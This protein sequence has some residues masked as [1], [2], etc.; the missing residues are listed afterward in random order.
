MRRRLASA[1]SHADVCL[2]RR[3]CA[4][5][6]KTGWAAEARNETKEED[7]PRP[8]V[9]EQLRA[10]YKMV[11]PDLFHRDPVA[12]AANESSFQLL[13]EYLN[14]SS[15]DET[16]PKS[17][18]FTFSFYTR[19]EGGNGTKKVDICLPP[20]SR[21]GSTKKEDER[22]FSLGTLK[23]LARLFEQ[24]GLDGNLQELQRGRMDEWDSMR[25]AEFLP[26]AVESLRQQENNSRTALFRETTVRT[27]LFVGRGVRVS[28]AQNMMDR[29][30]EDRLKVLEKLAHALDCLPGVNLQDLTIKLGN[31][32]G[33]D[34]NGML[35]LKSGGRAIDFINSISDANIQL[36]HRHRAIWKDRVTLE[37]Q[38]A[39]NLGIASI[40]TE[41][42]IASQP[43][44]LAFLERLAFYSVQEGR[45]TQ[46]DLSYVTLRV[47]KG[48][49]RRQKE[50]IGSLDEGT[51]HI[52]V[53]L[54]E[55]PELVYACVLQHG[56][57]AQEIS[58]AY[59]ARQEHLTRLKKLVRLRLGLRHIH[60]D[61]CVTVDQFCSCCS[62]LLRVSGAL[63][64][65]LE[66]SSLKI[67]DRNKV[68]SDGQCIFL[69]WDFRA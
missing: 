9:K 3:W 63:R 45:I 12:K 44:Y 22:S 41:P 54:D 30:A 37:K 11:H 27:A 28:Y 51:G 65:V 53:Q 42:S 16:Q 6:T 58:E 69:K 39:E 19:V 64:P 46:E 61:N 8:T 15:D 2:S 20:P 43:S 4:G 33:I 66:G 10:L 13:Q 25:L 29:A 36:A 35:W 5:R 34:R 59:V 1:V 50:H 18:L 68:C 47:C 38:I 17:S 31:R 14:F 55:H 24:C 32:S 21:H 57:R 56:R 52:L 48:W 49:Q 7:R 26:P 60:H 23:A 67:S 40:S 62:R